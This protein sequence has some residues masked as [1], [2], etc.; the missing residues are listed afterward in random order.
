M[1][2][3]SPLV[4]GRGEAP[5]SAP[6]LLAHEGVWTRHWQT[7][8]FTYRAPDL[9]GEGIERARGSTEAFLYRRLETLPETAGRFRLNAELPIPFD[10]R[11]E[12]KWT[13][14]CRIA[15]SSRLDGCQHLA[16]CRGLPT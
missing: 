16:G 5:R 8:L 6:G 14:F 4:V 9:T 10:G 1:S 7:C 11:A 12:W 3:C 15:N 2:G 13:C